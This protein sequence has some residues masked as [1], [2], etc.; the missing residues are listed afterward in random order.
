MIGKE[1]YVKFLTM[2]FETQNAA[3]SRTGTRCFRGCRR[4]VEKEWHIASA[5]DFPASSPSL[6]TMFRPS[7]F[8]ALLHTHHY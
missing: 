2:S 1:Y 5:S 3:Q 6:S 7:V 4:A 8:P